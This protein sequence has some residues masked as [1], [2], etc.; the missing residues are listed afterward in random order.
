V[1]CTALAPLRCLRA[2]IRALRDGRRPRSGWPRRAGRCPHGRLCSTIA[3]VGMAL[4]HRAAPVR[5]SPPSPMSAPRAVRRRGWWSRIG[6][7]VIEYPTNSVQIPQT[8]WQI[9]CTA[10]CWVRTKI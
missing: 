2:V 9:L 8:P 10:V 4:R 7:F 5:A 6:G 3:A 1:W